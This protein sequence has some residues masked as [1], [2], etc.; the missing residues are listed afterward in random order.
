M[1]SS[2]RHRV[3]SLVEAGK[4][5]PGDADSADADASGFDWFDW[6]IAILIV[7]NVIAL[8]LESEPDLHDRYHAAFHSFE[9]FSLIVFGVEYLLR[10]W[11][12]TADPAYAHPVLGRLRYATRPM[13]II[14]LLAILPG[15]LFFL[16]VPDMR[17]VRALRLLRILRVLKLGR[18]SDA[19]ALLGRV[20]S[21][22][23]A[24]L[25][26]M[27]MTL[28]ILLILSASA[29][30]VAEADEQPDAFGSITRSLWWAVI[31]LTTIG[32]G[33]VYPKTGLGRVLGGM[34][35]VLGI[36]MVALPTAIIASGFNDELTKA[37]EAKQ[38]RKMK[39]QAEQNPSIACPHCGM[40]IHVSKPAE[41]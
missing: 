12:C 39:Q 23:R 13:Q 7:L 3:W 26:V 20:L 18:Y 24:E 34:I 17:F 16:N 6:L 21:K 1:S 5:P 28:A 25:T 2:F 15:I 30:H 38:R 40:P 9:V 19:V 35:A 41:H 27:L 36:G 31:T 14:D 22:R 11:S 32:Y 33:D 37:R 10:L 29:L 4:R 8:V